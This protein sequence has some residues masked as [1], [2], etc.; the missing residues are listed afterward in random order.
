MRAPVGVASTSI[1]YMQPKRTNE[2]EKLITDL[3]IAADMVLDSA[4]KMLPG[5]LPHIQLHRMVAILSIVI[6]SLKLNNTSTR[7]PEN[8]N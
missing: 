1:T 2:N 3:E 8:L 5:S 7:G 6:E 4:N